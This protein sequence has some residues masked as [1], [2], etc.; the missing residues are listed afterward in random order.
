M[1][2][3]KIHPGSCFFLPE[4]REEQIPKAT[5]IVSGAIAKKA[6]KPVATP[7]P[8][9]KPKK[10]VNICPRTA[11]SPVSIAILSP[12]IVKA[13]YVGR[14]PFR[15]SKRSTDVPPVHPITLNTLLVPIFPLPTVRISNPRVS[16]GIQNPKGNEPTTKLR[17]K[18]RTAL[19]RISIILSPQRRGELSVNHVGIHTSPEPQVVQGREHLIILGF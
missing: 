4:G 18:S 8:P 11:P 9:R 1:S 10:G 17:V 19:R 2:E 14:N 13:K 6:P 5:E 12:M 15:I 3:S 16:F 7:F